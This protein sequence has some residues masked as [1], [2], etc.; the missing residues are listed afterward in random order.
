[1]ITG[2]PLAHEKF[3]HPI[4]IW[5]KEFAAHRY[6]IYRWLREEAPVYKGRVSLLTVYYVSRYE[7]CVALLRD[8]R[9]VRNRS[10]ATGGR[11]FPIP[12]P[13]SVELMV[14]SMINEDEPEHRRLRTL[15]HKAFTPRTLARLESRIAALTQELL[16]RIEGQREVD[17]TEAY[18]LPI[19]VTVIAEM[20][21]VEPEEVPEL[22]GYVR[23]LAR[24][25]SGIRILRTFTW[26]LPRA[27]RFIRTLIERKRAQPGDDILTALVEAEESGD[28]LTEDELVA[29]VFL[30]IVAGYETTVHLINNAVVALDAHPQELAR[31]KADPDLIPPAIEEVLRYMG[32]IQATKLHYALEDVQLR[33]VTIPQGTPVMPLLGAA[34]HDPTV[35]LEPERLDITRDPNRHLGFGQGIHYCLGAPLARLETRIALRALYERFPR[36]RLAVPVEELPMEHLPGWHRYGAVPVILE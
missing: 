2:R 5:S 8:R 33:G 13:R 16:D 36:L 10:T 31:L 9:F 14:K 25:F 3:K 32:P 22:G 4:N 26:D 30:L 20:V 28:R 27:A 1:M 23:A 11:R 21:G 7:D 15:V 18:A 35:F 19:P 12:M 17:L 34:N 29:M 24:G 6:A